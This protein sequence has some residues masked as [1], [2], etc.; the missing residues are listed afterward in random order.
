MYPNAFAVKE[1]EKVQ[2]VAL[3]APNGTWRMVCVGTCDCDCVSLSTCALMIHLRRGRGAAAWS[4]KL[5]REVWSSDCGVI[6]EDVLDPKL[7]VTH[8]ERYNVYMLLGPA[9]IYM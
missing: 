5:T 2:A 7:I 3:M 1:H 9:L 6:I 8:D 4:G